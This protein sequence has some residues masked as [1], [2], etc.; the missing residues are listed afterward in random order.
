MAKIVA[1]YAWKIPTPL[2]CA[3]EYGDFNGDYTDDEI[4][5]VKRFWFQLSDIVKSHKASHYT[6]EY[7]EESSFSTY[8]RPFTTIASAGDVTD[9]KIHIFK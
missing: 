2:V 3:V 1:E 7:A 4:A 8:E 5:A 6:I 9:S